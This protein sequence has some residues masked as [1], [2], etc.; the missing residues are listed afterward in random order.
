M[1]IGYINF[2]SV[3]ILCEWSIFRSSTIAIL[4]Y[5]TLVSMVNCF[6][7]YSIYLFY[8]SFLFYKS[9]LYIYIYV[10]Y[11]SVLYI[12]FII[13]MYKPIDAA[14]HAMN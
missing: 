7:N 3:K 10:Y 6:T 11:L 8:K 9:T 12:C 4:F 13:Y 14:I 1:Q 2:Y 5:R